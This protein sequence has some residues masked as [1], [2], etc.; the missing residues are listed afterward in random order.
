MLTEQWTG[1]NLQREQWTENKKKARTLH[2]NTPYPPPSG[3]I[4]R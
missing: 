1:N 3:T 2:G 4:T